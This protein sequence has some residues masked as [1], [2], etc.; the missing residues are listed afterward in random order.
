MEAGGEEAAVPVPCFCFCF[1]FCPLSDKSESDES[2]LSES[3]EGE[4]AGLSGSDF[5]VRGRGRRGPSTLPSR[6]GTPT[7]ATTS[8]RSEK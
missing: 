2:E 6:F 4:L 7:P 8:N 5:F 3:D 1:C